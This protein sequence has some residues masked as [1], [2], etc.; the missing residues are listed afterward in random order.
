MTQKLKISVRFWCSRNSL[1][2]STG[3]LCVNVTLGKC[4]WRA[5]QKNC[6]WKE[7]KQLI[8]IVI[9]FIPIHIFSCLYP[10]NVIVPPPPREKMQKK[11]GKYP[12]KWNRVTKISIDVVFHLSLHIYNH[13]LLHI[14][15]LKWNIIINVC[16]FMGIRIVK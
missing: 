13:Y 6:R 12:T 16:F 3:W 8:S 15:H 7:I 10:F 9:I 1:R 5:S 11:K 4:Y 14:C 2:Q